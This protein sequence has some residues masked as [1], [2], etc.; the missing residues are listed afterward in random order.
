MQK[1]LFSHHHLQNSDMV[2]NLATPFHITIFDAAQHL[3]E[4][5]VTPTFLSPSQ[6]NGK[7]RNYESGFPYHGR[8]DSS[9]D[10]QDGTERGSEVKR[11]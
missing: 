7:L 6:N 10:L 8:G 5:R 2:E 9:N 4:N 3:A 1:F 11:L